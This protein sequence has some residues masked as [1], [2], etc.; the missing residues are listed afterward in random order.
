VVSLLGFHCSAATIDEFC[1]LTGADDDDDI[2]HDASHQAS[3]DGAASTN[4][5]KVS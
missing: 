4:A 3:G 2:A 1:K 5:E